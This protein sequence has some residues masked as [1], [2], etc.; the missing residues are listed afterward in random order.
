MKPSIYNKEFYD[1]NYQTSH[2][3]AHEIFLILFTK[4]KP[5]NIL[6]VG[7]GVGTWLKA[8]E[9]LGVKDILGLD[10]NYVNSAQ[11][12]IDGDNFKA[13][14]LA[15]P[16]D[17]QRKFELVISME[18]AEHL[19]KESARDFVGSLCRHGNI[20]LFSAAIPMQGGVFHVN[21]QWQSYWVGKF[22]EH[23]F[24]PFDLIRPFIWQNDSVAEYYKQNT[25]VFVNSNDYELVSRV[26]L[27]KQ[28]TPPIFDIVHPDSY[29]LKSN[30][31]N[32]ALKDVILYLPSILKRVLKNRV[33]KK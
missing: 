11:L 13:C 14:D 26:E 4:F 10:G 25:I 6:D 17:L 1:F 28:A 18:V 33:F 23:S 21:E 2:K 29:M 22:A 31:L 8:A 3:S 9:E 5:Q 30:P 27:M 16:F 7:C 32:W 20:I 12:L 19:P 24:Q 15:K